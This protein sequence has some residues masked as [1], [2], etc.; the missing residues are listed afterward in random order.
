MLVI[1]K[2]NIKF[3]IREEAVE[4]AKAFKKSCIDDTH[5]VEFVKVD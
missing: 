3:D 1:L 2:A 5:R 4:S